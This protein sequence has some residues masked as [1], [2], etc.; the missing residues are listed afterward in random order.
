MSDQSN[1]TK[2]TLDMA[3]GDALSEKYLTPVASPD[4]LVTESKPEEP[5]NANSEID[6]DVD[7]GGYWDDWGGCTDP[8]CER[9]IP[10]TRDWDEESCDDLDC[11]CGMC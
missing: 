7:S 8:D 6:S 5:T 4:K 11:S 10:D 1:V 2:V 3:I 9:C